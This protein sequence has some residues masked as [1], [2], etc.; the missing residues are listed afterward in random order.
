[1]FVFVSC[2][3]HSRSFRVC[4]ELTQTSMTPKTTSQ[5]CGSMSASGKHI[6]HSSSVTVTV[7]LSI[8]I[9]QL[10]P[11]LYP[12]VN[13]F[14]LYFTLPKH[15]GAFVVYI[16]HNICCCCFV[17]DFRVFSDRLVDHTDMEA[18][19][20]LLGEKLG[21]LFNLTFHNICPNKQPPIFGTF[22]IVHTHACTL[23]CQSVKISLQIGQWIDNGLWFKQYKTDRLM[24]ISDMN[25]Y[26]CA[27]LS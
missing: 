14:L 22:I 8:I 15:L 27:Y 20:A 19:I 18:F 3:A 1:M 6:Y 23:Q 2:S 10:K 9:H 7:S 12:V 4:S 21:S 17:V 5:D 25:V 16:F 26:T 11:C 24:T 13:G